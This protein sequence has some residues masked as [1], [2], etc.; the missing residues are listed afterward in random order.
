[1]I[2]IFD[3]D[4][5]D[6]DLGPMPTPAARRVASSSSEDEASEDETPQ[7]AG[8]DGVSPAVEK[9]LHRAYLEHV[10]VFEKRARRTKERQELK[11]KTGGMADDLLESW[12][13]MFDRDVR[14]RCPSWSSIVRRADHGR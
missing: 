10:G 12:K 11:D 8:G 3:S 5:E 2:D 14:L 7:R 6:P 4:Y 13:A 9:V 1:M